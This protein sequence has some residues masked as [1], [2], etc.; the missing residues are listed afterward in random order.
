MLREKRYKLEMDAFNAKMDA[1][2]KAQS[3]AGWKGTGDAATTGDFKALKE[4]LDVNEFVGYEQYNSH[5]K[6]TR[7]S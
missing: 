5:S 1:K 7:T 4:K 2:Q 3:K 6:S